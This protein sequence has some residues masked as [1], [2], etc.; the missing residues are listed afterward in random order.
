MFRS[1]IDYLRQIEATAKGMMPLHQNDEELRQIIV[2]VGEASWTRMLAVLLMARQAL[3]E[4]DQP[5]VFHRE[6]GEPTKQLNAL[7]QDLQE[8]KAD[9]FL[10][11]LSEMRHACRRRN[12]PLPHEIIFPMEAKPAIAE[13]FKDIDQMSVS[14]FTCMDLKIRLQERE[15]SEIESSTV[16]P[17]VRDCAVALCSQAGYDPYAKWYPPEGPETFSDP[18]PKWHEFIPQAEAATAAIRKSLRPWRSIQHKVD[19]RWNVIINGITAAYGFESEQ[20]ADK[21]AWEYCHRELGMKVP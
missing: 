20:D 1:P 14:A 13:M 17:M 6:Y 9:G 21:W 3:E 2:K 15:P 4:H 8:R 18:Y 7:L 16:D 10:G 5:T 12:I 11:A 19:G